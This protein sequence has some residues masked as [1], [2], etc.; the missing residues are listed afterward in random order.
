M[1]S[2]FGFA[3]LAISFWSPLAGAAPAEIL[4]I[5]HA[6]KISDSEPGLSPKGFQRANALVDLFKKDPR[7]LDYG[8]PVAIF[9]GTAKHSDGSIRPLQTIQPLAK[10][11]GLT[12]RTDFESK[13]DTAMVA[14]IMSNPAYNG[15]TVL[16][17]W[18]HQEIPDIAHALGMKKKKIPNWDGGTFDRVWKF[19][20]DNG[21]VASFE[22]LPERALPGDSQN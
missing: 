11:L 14:S 2:F 8:T 7:L 4:V 17:C 6:E 3:L 18:P 19:T 21:D 13:D 10:A 5:R 12:P 20:I 9:A 15:K 1:K 16:I 22:D